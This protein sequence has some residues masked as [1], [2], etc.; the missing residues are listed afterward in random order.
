M[1][2]NRTWDYQFSLGLRIHFTTM[3][4]THQTLA[5]GSFAVIVLEPVD[6]LDAHP[7][8]AGVFAS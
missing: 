4:R 1:A 5:N 7:A 6:E 3:A 2:W 8:L